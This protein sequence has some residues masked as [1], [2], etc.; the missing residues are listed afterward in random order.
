MDTSDQARVGA[1][2]LMDI[3]NLLAGTFYVLDEAGHFILWNRRLEQTTGLSADQLRAIHMLDLVDL[4]DRSRVEDAFRTVLQQ[5]EQV[6]LEARLYLRGRPLPY[7][8]CGTRLQTG[9]RNY[10]CG[11]GVDLSARYLQREALELRERALHAASNGIII[12]RCD[13]GN[14]PIEY[15]NPA[16]ERITGYSAD[17]VLGHDARMMAAPGLDLPQR[18]VLHAAIAAHQPCS[19][20]LRNRR[21]TGELFWNQLSV[22]PVHDGSAGV[23]HYIGIIEDISALKERTAQL[24]HQ[25][26]HDALTGVANRTLLRDRLEHAIHAAHR[27]GGN[28]AVALLDLNK[29]K[30]IN[31]TMGHDAGDQVLK[32]VA[33]RLLAAVRDT[34]TVSRLGGDEFVLVLAEQPN[35]RFTLRMIERVRQALAQDLRIDGRDLSLGASMGVAV[36]PQDGDSFSSLL[37]AADAAMYTG[38]G[39]G[40]GAVHFY[41][42]DMAT[43]SESRARLE[44][45]L[46]AAIGDEQIYLLYQ[47]HVCVASGE[48][49]GIEALLR[50]RHPERGELLPADFLA[51]AEENG[52]IIPLGRR[53]LEDVCSTLGRLAD[54]GFGEVPISINSSNRE[55]SQ[56][57][58]LGHIARRIAHYGIRPGLL[59][60]ELK[61]SQLMNNP[62]RAQKFAFGVQKL[63]LGLNVDEFGAGASNLACLEALPVRRLKMS[64][65]PVW[66]IGRAGHN[67]ALAKTMLDIGN[68]LN[69]EVVATCVETQT[70]RDFL[71]AHGCSSM[72]GNFVTI[73]LTRPALE[74]W[75][76]AR[77]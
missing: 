56:R 44:A 62:E 35:L 75:L 31:D 58:Y 8:L 16:F 63:G 74:Q 20:V 68:N 70:Q 24:E 47:P 36:Y 23:T 66:N 5:Q 51:D 13:G 6:Q 11:M 40:P 73:P 25:V 52:L 41:S 1:V 69:M 17:E 61:E 21:K 14:N 27:S 22:T 53:V 55:I 19:V 38:K 39:G 15:I 60:I 10:L 46:R 54:I 33:G 50:W 3:M 65:V 30:E 42:A 67:G 76:T 12:T 28:V 26:T 43:S 64:P 7:L 57:D 34:D 9:G 72:Q 29:F 32:L 4:P 2:P 77:Q 45:A 48:L 49:H 37:K 18:A 71:A 59:E